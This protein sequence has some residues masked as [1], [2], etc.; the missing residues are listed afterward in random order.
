MSSPLSGH[1]EP[2]N[3]ISTSICWWAPAY[4]CCGEDLEVQLLSLSV[5]FL[6]QLVV[7]FYL[8]IRLQSLTFNWSAGKTCWFVRAQQGCVW[9]QVLSA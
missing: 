9:Y 1:A 4:R 6:T 8:D 2:G 5:I 7:G 3:A